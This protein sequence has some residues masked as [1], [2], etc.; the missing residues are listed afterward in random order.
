[1]GTM[2]ALL[3]SRWGRRLAIGVALNIVREGV[4]LL[5]R[6]VDGLMDRALEPQVRA[7]RYAALFPAA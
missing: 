3:A 5:R 7:Q 4:A 2:S 6:S 1:M